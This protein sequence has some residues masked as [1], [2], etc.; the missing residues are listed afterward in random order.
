MAEAVRD[1]YRG[2]L[3]VGIG[4][5]TGPVVVGT[6]GGG[7]RL[8][9]TVIGDAVNTAARVESTTRQT[10]DDLLITEATRRALSRELDGWAERPGVTLK[11]KTE[12]VRVHAS[13]KLA[14]TRRDPRRNQ[15]D[16][17]DV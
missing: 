15:P 9:F 14:S 4:I 5:N 12:I 7:G 1:R 16:P 17:A 10:G 3:S 8:D 13:L 11:G 2:E 6:I